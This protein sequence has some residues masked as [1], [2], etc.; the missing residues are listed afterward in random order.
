MFKETSQANIDKLNDEMNV[1]LSGIK[2]G[3]VPLEMNLVAGKGTD[4]DGNLIEPSSFEVSMQE[5]VDEEELW[6]TAGDESTDNPVSNSEQVID[7]LIDSCYKG[8]I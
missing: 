2:G 1:F 7:L 5:Q 4:L 3:F 8:K 6:A